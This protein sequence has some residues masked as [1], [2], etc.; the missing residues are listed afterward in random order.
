M[1]LTAVPAFA[2]DAASGVREVVV[3]FK[4]HFDIGYTDLAAKVVEGY[5]TTMIDKALGIVDQS[6]DLP[7]EQRFVWTLPGWPMAQILDESQTPERRNRVTAALKDGRFVV[8][9]LPFTLHTESLDLEDL[10]RGLGYASGVA[11]ALDLELP[12]DAKMT[13][14]PSHSW[15]I[16][17]LLKHAGVDFLHLGCNAGSASPDLPRLFWWEGP[18]GSRLLTMYTAEAY[19]TGLIPP[20]DWPYPVWLALI[21]T[22]DNQGPPA[23]EAVQKLLEEAQRSLPGVRVRLGRLSDFGDALL[24]HT[25]NFPIVRA[26]T[27]DTWIHG[28]MSMPIETRLARRGRPQLAA[29]EGLNTL[30][31]GWGLATADD[32]SSIAA[33]YAG[34]LLFGEHTWGMDVKQFGP[35]LYGEEWEQ[36]HAAGR[37]QKLEASWAE[38]GA[39]IHWMDRLLRDGLDHNLSALGQG[40]NVDG[41]RIVVYNPL[42]WPRDGLVELALP[43]KVPVALCAVDSGDTTYIDRIDQTII[44]FVATAIPA[45]GYRTYVWAEEAHETM[46]ADHHIGSSN[47]LENAFFRIVMDKVNGSIASLVDKRTGRDWVDSAAEPRFGQYLYERFSNAEVERY[48]KAYAKIQADWAFE[49]FGKSGLPPAD[50]T[51]YSATTF[52]GCVLERQLGHNTVSATM[53]ARPIPQGPRLSVT[54]YRHLP[55]V[56]ITWSVENKKAEPWPEAGWLC[57]PFA[58]SNP[59]FRLGRLGGLVNPATEI[60]NGANHDVYCL[61]TGCVILDEHRAG[62]A[63]CPL[64]SPLVSLD[65]PGLWRYSRDFVPTKAAVYVNLFNNQW[66]TNFQQWSQGAWSSTVRLW[67]FTD[68]DAESGF[69]TPALEARTPLLAAFHDGPAGALPPADQGVE[70]SRKGVLVTAFGRNPD[71]DGL[72]LR[73]W[74]QAGQGGPCEVTLPRA[75][76]VERVQPC[77]LR[78]RPVGE[79]IPVQESRFKID[80]TAYAPVS[81]LLST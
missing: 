38:K 15:V 70:L 62:V 5:R 68:F 24:A 51:A 66:S 57:F 45:M 23:P 22:G 7:P 40:V 6:R 21:H 35:R 43:S 10:V 18:D 25:R 54:I 65:R 71:G 28:V 67:T 75:F 80:L 64:D 61:N 78:G 20:Q 72:V 79:S 76:R 2:E 31:H 52:K 36:A 41:P 4:T 37:Y 55:C 19:G 12:R 74:E 30:S 69:I 26:D 48:V 29:W 13:D 32:A 39:H 53:G 8:H 58:I 77:D 3:V 59:E 50:L 81:I 34:S 14:V 17:T 9:A 46:Y 56:D 33:A 44:R 60:V 27:P 42:P 63:I 16:P 1:L 47:S 11:R 73:L 49:D